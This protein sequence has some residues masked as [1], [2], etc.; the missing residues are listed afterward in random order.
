MGV[1]VGGTSDPGTD[2]LIVDGQSLL[3]RCSD[4]Y[5][6]V[7][8]RFGPSGIDELSDERWKK[9]V[10]QIEDALQKS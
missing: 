9:D 1:H 8:G 4:G 6:Y 2:N 5:V 3:E 10:V 7:N